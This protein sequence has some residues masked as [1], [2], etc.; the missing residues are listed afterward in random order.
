[1]RAVPGDRKPHSAARDSRHPARPPT[2]LPRSWRQPRRRPRR[3]A[4]RPTAAPAPAS[5]RASAP[6]TTR[7]RPPR[8]RRRRS[9]PRPARKL[10]RSAG[11]ARSRP[12][13]RRR[14]RPARRWRSC[15]MP[16]RPPTRSSKRRPRRR[17]TASARPSVTHTICSA[18]PAAPPT[19]SAT[20]ASSWP[21]TCARWAI[22]CA[23]T[24]SACSAMSSRSTARWW[25][26]SIASRTPRGG[27]RARTRASADRVQ[28]RDDAIEVPEFI[29]GGKAS[30]E[31]DLALD[32][33]GRIWRVQCKWGRLS[34]GQDVVIVHTSG[35][36]LSPRGYVRTPYAPR[37]VD[38]FGI[39]CGVSRPKLPP[40]GFGHGWQA[41]AVLAADPNPQ[42]T[43]RVYY[44]C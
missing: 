13:S 17:P 25:P 5:P 18:R 21:P 1:M 24:P 31:C 23:P 40:V 36:R 38:L 3:S 32:I 28:P 7:S 9:S 27:R 6:P 2:A 42:P 29:P 8:K 11:R 12:R 4:A 22:P 39:Y 15:P 41:R 16:T 43:A 35:T 30:D 34:R 37:D 33:G 20:R 26:R 19:R 10:N 14:P 44:P